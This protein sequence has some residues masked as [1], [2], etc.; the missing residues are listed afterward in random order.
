[1]IAKVEHEEKFLQFAI[2]QYSVKYDLQWSK[3][4]FLRFFYLF[5]Y[6]V[7][8]NYTTYRKKKN[9]TVHYLHYLRPNTT[10]LHGT[11]KKK[12]KERLLTKD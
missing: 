1:M 6:L 5:T 3:D 7:I 9:D 4:F 10:I 2:V 11:G 8:N 12:Q